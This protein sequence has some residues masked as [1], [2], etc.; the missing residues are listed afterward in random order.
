[1][2]TFIPVGDS[3]HFEKTAGVKWRFSVLSTHAFTVLCVCEIS[4]K[5]PLGLLMIGFR[6][7][8]R[9][10]GEFDI[11]TPFVIDTFCCHLLN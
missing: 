10:Y 3:F 5:S 8:Y 7:K 2:F 1:M 9:L 6:S 11:V 4:A